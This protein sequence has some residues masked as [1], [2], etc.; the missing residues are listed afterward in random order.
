MRSVIKGFGNLQTT[1]VNLDKIATDKYFVKAK[2]KII[3]IYQNRLWC[4]QEI[5]D[6]N[7][8]SPKGLVHKFVNDE[9]YANEK[10]LEITDEILS[11]G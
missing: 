1:L 7:L 6:Q 9:K 2:A 4:L 3:K 10:L 11:N 5:N 8:F